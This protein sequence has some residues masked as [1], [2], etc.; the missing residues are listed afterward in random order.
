MHTIKSRVLG[1]EHPSTLTT[2]GNLAASLSRQD[3][4]AEAEAIYHDV[5]RGFKRVLG[6]E[7]PTTIRAARNLANFLC[8]LKLASEAT[9]SEAATIYREVV[10]IQKQELRFLKFR[11]IL[12]CSL[13][14]ISLG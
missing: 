6:P 2:A 8:Y 10:G 4:D 12:E 13:E 1:P 11:L 7:H 9:Y 14:S 5:L 3:K